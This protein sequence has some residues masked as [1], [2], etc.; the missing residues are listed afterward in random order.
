MMDPRSAKNKIFTGIYQITDKEL[1]QKLGELSWIQSYAKGEI[2]QSA[3]E[4]QE[5]AAFLI[6]G[7]VRAYYTSG[8]GEEITDCF[9]DG[10]GYPT[11][12]TDYPH[13]Q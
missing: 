7:V 2:I 12:T 1:L 9:I 8:K 5:F 3:G 6:S 11:L 10:F 4:E 13:R